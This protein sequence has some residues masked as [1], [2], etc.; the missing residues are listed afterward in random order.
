M[1][2]VNGTPLIEAGRIDNRVVYAC[3]NDVPLSPRMKKTLAVFGPGEWLTARDV[4]GRTGALC[5]HCMKGKTPTRVQRD[6]QDLCVRGDLKA[7]HQKHRGKIRRVYG[8]PTGG[9]P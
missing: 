5:P 2:T 9:G 7:F 1:I 6:L 3:G 8:K 4:A